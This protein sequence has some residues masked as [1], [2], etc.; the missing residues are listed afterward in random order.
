MAVTA[1]DVFKIVTVNK[2]DFTVTYGGKIIRDDGEV[3]QKTGGLAK[4]ILREAGWTSKVLDETKT[5]PKEEKEDLSDY[6][7]ED[8]QD[9][10][11]T[12]YSAIFEG[13]VKFFKDQFIPKKK[14]DVAPG[15]YLERGYDIWEY[16][17][18]GKW[19][20]H[21]LSG[22]RKEVSGELAKAIKFTVEYE[23][24]MEPIEL[25]S[26]EFFEALDRKAYTTP[27][28][29]WELWK[30]Y[31]GPKAVEG[32]VEFFG[33]LV[34]NVAD[35]PREVVMA[36]W[37]GDSNVLGWDRK[38]Q[39][40]FTKKYG[41]QLA[42]AMVD[43]GNPNADQ[44]LQLFTALP[45]EFIAEIY[46]F[47]LISNTGK[48]T[49]TGN[50]AI[51]AYE[52]EGEGVDWKKFFSNP[53]EYFKKPIISVKT[54]VVKTKALKR[55][56]G[57]TALTSTLQVKTN[58]LPRTKGTP[59]VWPKELPK[60]KTKALKKRLPRVPENIVKVR[61][62]PLVRRIPI[63]APVAVVVK[64][65]P[66]PRRKPQY[67]EYALKVRT[68]RLERVSKATIS[69]DLPIVK[70][71]PL[72][73]GRAIQVSPGIYR[74]K[75]RELPRIT[76]QVLDATIRRVT[77]RKLERLINLLPSTAL[78]VKTKILQRIPGTKAR[79]AKLWVDAAKVRTLK[80]LRQKAPLTGLAK[81]KTKVLNRIKHSSITPI[82]ATIVN[83]RPLK[84]RQRLAAITASLVV[85]TRPLRRTAIAI[86]RAVVRIPV[87]AVRVLHRVTTKPLLAISLF[88][89][90]A[91]I[92]ILRKRSQLI[93]RFD[94]KIKI[95]KRNIRTLKRKTTNAVIKGL[96]E[97]IVRVLIRT[98][99]IE[100]PAQPQYRP[101]DPVEAE[102]LRPGIRTPYPQYTAPQ[103]PTTAAGYKAVTGDV[104]GVGSQVT[105]NMRDKFNRTRR[106]G[107]IT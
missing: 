25:G 90:R 75:T 33:D 10:G 106:V 17:A 23:D 45:L 6:E 81:F 26:P 20:R 16:T 13:V 55:L 53:K 40:T 41:R 99:H 30:N 101:S 77:V 21:S 42:E 37:T 52:A 84:R 2:R 31:S 58:P 35:L 67:S 50:L 22:G 66:L 28:R 34:V 73:R 49:E 32:L 27:E 12:S 4:H 65:T 91:A 8:T 102:P 43:K 64:T 69:S 3:I 63:S 36:L 83:T 76:R 71:H 48:I 80:R 89:P 96:P 18:D 5:K 100:T 44:M 86:P 105:S 47:K 74:V 70:T 92:R 104:L 51:K 60:V 62:V 19:Y 72:T 103:R 46:I 9:T 38:T 61:T 79:A 15:L 93:K 59:F 39:V 107:N 82:R 88:I 98:R 56:E 94:V 68:R 85:E 95:A 11:K 97:V 14:R 24:K 29:L 78:K 7:G 57:G 54:P 1:D 87:T